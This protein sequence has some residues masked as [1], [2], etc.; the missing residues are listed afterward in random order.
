MLPKSFLP[1]GMD[2]RKSKRARARERERR[3]ERTSQLARQPWD[4]TVRCRKL[5]LRIRAHTIAKQIY[6]NK[7]V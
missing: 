2:V 1:K 7:D 3:R 6:S 5:R 4:L